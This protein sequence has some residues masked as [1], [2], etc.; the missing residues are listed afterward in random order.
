MGQEANDMTFLMNSCMRN[1]FNIFKYKKL[2]KSREII[3]FPDDEGNYEENHEKLELAPINV[4]ELNV[5]AID[6]TE[7]TAISYCIDKN[8]RELLNRLLKMIAEND[9]ELYKTA[10]VT[11]LQI[12]IDAGLTQFFAE[13]TGAIDHFATENK[14]KHELKPIIFEFSRKENYYFYQIDNKR[15]CFILSCIAQDNWFFQEIIQ[16]WKGKP[17]NVT[18]DGWTPLLIVLNNN[19]ATKFTL[20]QHANYKIEK[21]QVKPEKLNPLR[22]ATQTTIPG[23]FE[24]VMNALP[25]DYKREI[26]NIED[27]SESFPL[28]PAIKNRNM[29]MVKE[30]LRLGA[31]PDKA[32]KNGVT[33]TF[34]AYMWSGQFYNSFLEAV[35]E[36]AKHRK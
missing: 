11:D 2:K 23:A 5:T 32:N 33:S 34:Y 14:D 31:N 13:I 9:V 1:D 30:L 27:E 15:D 36:N 7:M 22:I 8:N 25:D 29:N 21:K 26:V 18:N 17:Y 3:L 35:K 12:C 10:I 16:S 20:M 19:D 4:G 28:F 24:Y 6:K